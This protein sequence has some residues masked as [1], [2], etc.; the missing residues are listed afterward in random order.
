MRD[1]FL[2]WKMIGRS[3]ESPRSL[4]YNAIAANTGIVLQR[5]G[6][7]KWLGA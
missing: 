3:G 7:S 2:R 6:R 4:W 5:S 1:L